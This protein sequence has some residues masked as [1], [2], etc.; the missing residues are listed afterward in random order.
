[1]GLGEITEMQVYNYL[2][3]IT[4]IANLLSMVSDLY[5]TAVSLIDIVFENNVCCICFKFR[6]PH[7]VY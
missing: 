2:L 1:M 3:N 4:V 6:K 5:E 7:T